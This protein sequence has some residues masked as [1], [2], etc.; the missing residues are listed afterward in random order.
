MTIQFLRAVTFTCSI[1]ILLS[2]PARAQTRWPVD[3]ANA[4][5]NQQPWLVG[6][7][8]IPANAINE[9]EMWQADTFD[10]KRIDTE[11][12]WAEHLGMTTLRVFLHD[13]L[14]TQDT[15]G[16]KKRIDQFLSI[17]AT[18]K[19]RPIFVLFDSVW[20]PNPVLGP[21]R[22]PKP[23][24]HNSG[25]VQSPGAAGL[26]DEKNYS[27][28][29]DYVKGMVEAYGHDP[30]V[31]C[32]DIW[33]EPDNFNENNYAEPRNKIALV[34]KLLPLAFAWAREAHP[35]QP[36]TS[37]VWKLEYANFKGLSAVEKIQ[38]ENSDIV[39]FHNY[40]DSANF[41]KEI[42]FLAQYRRPLL[43]TEYL[44]RSYHSTFASILPLG[45]ANHVGMI[46]WGFVVGKTQTNLPWDS[47]QSPYING[48]EPS[49]W[50]HEIFYPDGR[51][52]QKEEVNLIRSLTGAK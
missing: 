21:Q 34:E 3:Q 17:C 16:F 51:P 41:R 18:H 13:L 30:R 5:Y 39:S 35:V 8:Y 42:N 48:R 33:N 15:A 10:P 20:D 9:L 11:L 1:A 36:L 44:A 52:Y 46:N 49:L 37:G 14:W 27:R 24:I 45:K 7:N 26:Q 38:L 2:S 25:W 29:R 23:G 43:C 4:W 28:L 40:S 32:W 22:A 31:L 19:I 6:C 47:W 12:G 50:H